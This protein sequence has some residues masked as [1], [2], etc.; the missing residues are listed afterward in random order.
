M[1]P[2]WTIVAWDP[3][4]AGPELWQAFHVYRRQRAKEHDAT[5]PVTEDAVVEGHMRKP[6]VWSIDH[7]YL[8]RAGDRVAIRAA[9]LEA[10]ELPVEL[11][12]KVRTSIL[13]VAP[14]LHRLGRA[15]LNPP[16]KSPIF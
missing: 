15:K 13:F 4:R 9:D 5:N 14:L 8:A 12:E 7:R 2:E 16:G 6:D 1:Q 10:Q 11:C 3:N